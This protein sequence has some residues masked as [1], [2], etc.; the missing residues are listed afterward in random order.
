MICHEFV[1]HICTAQSII[2]LVVQRVVGY[3]KLDMMTSIKPKKILAVTGSRAEFGLL[4]PLLRKLAENPRFALSIAATGAHL[5]KKFGYTISEIESAGFIVKHRI[6]SGLD[7]YSDTKEGTTLATADTIRGFAKLFQETENEPY[8]LVLGLGD[9][10]EL[11][12]ACVASHLAL[13]PFAHIGGG[14]I[15]EAALDDAL[16]HSITKLSHLHFTTTADCRM[17]VIQLGEAPEFTHN[18][19]CL[20]LDNILNL[21]PVSRT[22]LAKSLLI[23]QDSLSGRIL[24]VTFHP[25]TLEYGTSARQLQEL[26][27]ALSSLEKDIKIIF[28]LGNADTEGYQLNALIKEYVNQRDGAFAFQSLGLVRYLSLMKICCGVIGNSSSGITEA[29]SFQV[30]TVNIGNRQK[31]RLRVASIVD[32]QPVKAEIYSAIQKVLSPEFQNQLSTVVNAYGD[33]K[34][35]EKIISHLEKTNFATLIPKYFNDMN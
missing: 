27:L 13:V 9:R 6:N 30:G 14:E 7:S 19:G 20:S 8:D 35:S 21:N 28:T 29:P 17:R 25:V 1:P 15:T 11:F 22:E 16:R 31:G 2:G 23:P 18:V 26:L 5:S 34:T 24:L 32:A 4:L 12:S 33:G 3:S 10:Y